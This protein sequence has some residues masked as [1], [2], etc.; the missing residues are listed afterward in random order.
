MSSEADLSDRCECCG[1][2]AIASWVVDFHDGGPVFLACER[3]ALDSA[4][5]GLATAEHIE[6]KKVTP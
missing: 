4:E 2:S 5:R 3:C 6:I 1:W